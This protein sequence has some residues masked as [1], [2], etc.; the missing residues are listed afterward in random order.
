MKYDLCTVD[1]LML[2]MMGKPSVEK[3]D[4]AGNPVCAI[5]GSPHP[6]NRHHI[7]RRGAGKVVQRGRE[8]K[9][10]TVTLCGIGN[11]CG[12]HK[13]AHDGRL[14][15][16]WVPKIDKAFYNRSARTN[17]VCGHWEYLITEDPTKYQDALGMKG[18][19][20]L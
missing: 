12:C 3:V 15:F 9:K 1:E 18:W 11:T 19:R 5:C 16:R 20:K 14:H 7:V 10:P 6:L 17:L 8:L 4:N 13:L 2:P